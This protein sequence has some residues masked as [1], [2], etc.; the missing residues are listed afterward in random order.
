MSGGIYQITNKTNGKMYIGLCKDFNDRWRRHYQN[1]QAN[2]NRPNKHLQA[3]WN[4]YGED[5]FTFSVL[6]EVKNFSRLEAIEE[7]YIKYSNSHISEFGYNKC[8][9]GISW[10]GCF[11]SEDS[12]KKMRKVKESIRNK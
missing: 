12:K 6:E 4:K 5:A 9:S 10:L 2:R 11:H 8:K 3:S 1:L 7:L